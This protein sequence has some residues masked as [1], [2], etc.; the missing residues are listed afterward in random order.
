[1]IALGNASYSIYL[2]QWLTFSTFMAQGVAANVLLVPKIL[3]AWLMTVLLS[4]GCYHYFER[5]ARSFIRRLLAAER[6]RGLLPGKRASVPVT[7]DSPDLS[8]VRS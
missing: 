3:L 2:L 6:V 8:N 7:A 1:M 4:L 5:P